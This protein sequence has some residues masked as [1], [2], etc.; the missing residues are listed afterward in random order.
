MGLLKELE[1]IQKTNPAKCKIVN[2]ATVYELVTEKKVVV[3]VKYKDAKGESHTE[4]GPVVI[5]TGG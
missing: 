3:G 5:C 4:Y 2:K 1:R